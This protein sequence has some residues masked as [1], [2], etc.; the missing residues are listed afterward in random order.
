MP[1]PTAHDVIDAIVDEGTFS[2]T[3]TRPLTTPKDE[4][5]ALELRVARE[6][7]DVDEA[8]ITGSAKI[9]GM[10]V[11]L[12]VGDFGF[13]AGSIGYDAAMRVVRGL[14][15]ATAAGL[16][17]VAA[18][19]SGGTRMQEGTPAFLRMVP[20]AQ[21]VAVHRAE[22]LPYI[23]YQ[24]SPTTGGVLATWGS[25]GQVTLAEPGALVGFL[26]PRVYEALYGSPF[27][28]GVQVTENLVKRGIVDQAVPLAELRGRLLSF[29]RVCAQ[30]PG[31]VP[32]WAE[33]AK[34]PPAPEL[35]DPDTLRDRLVA[36]RR[37]EAAVSG[38][39]EQP[40][41]AP[42]PDPSAWQRIEKTRRTSRPG[43]RELLEV[44]A[45]DLIR[46]S[47][48][49]QGEKTPGLICGLARIGTHGV[50]LAGQDRQSQ[51]DGS[52]LDGSSLRTMRRGMDLAVELGLPF[53]SIVDTGG[54]ELSAR[55]EERALA[56]E[57]ARVLADLTVLQ[58]PTVSVLLGEGGGGA[59]LAGLPADRVIAA[60]NSWLTPLPPEGAAAI[61]LRDPDRADEM[62]AS[63]RVTAFHLRE[64]GAVDE[65]VP[66]DGDWLRSIA[67]ALDAALHRVSGDVVSRQESA[68]VSP[69][70][71]A[72]RARRW[73]QLAMPTV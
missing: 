53:V 72:R 9:G 20:I 3:T 44:A 52:K 37:E 21:A 10:R 57:I 62:A 27:P 41:P 31:P 45:T 70:R 14:E 64:V 49:G 1:A 22:G 38:A 58:T 69:E 50:V 29:L 28:S 36:G 4:D 33:G 17:V 13:L 24:R 60:E 39:A 56:G 15:Y 67:E 2:T 6:R 16:P 46:F 65:I 47:G 25:L 23:V 40:E 7:T 68:T 73:R 11:Q 43:V 42:H 63:Q 55:A 54:A 71:L 66:E 48:N 12:I 51:R 26:G 19:I 30:R 8:V 5:Y 61:R 35:L 18:P 32:E 59:A 34:I